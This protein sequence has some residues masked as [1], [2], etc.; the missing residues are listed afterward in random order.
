[1]IL[2]FT[3]IEGQWHHMAPT[4]FPDGQTPSVHD[5]ANR[6][7]ALIG[8]YLPALQSAWELLPGGA[9]VMGQGAHPET[10]SRKTVWFLLISSRFSTNSKCCEFYN[11]NCFV[12]FFSS[13]VLW[14]CC[15]FSSRFGADAIFFSLWLCLSNFSFGLRTCSQSLIS[16][17]G[18]VM[19]FFNLFISNNKVYHCSSFFCRWNIWHAS[20]SRNQRGYGCCCQKFFWCCHYQKHL[21]P[22][23]ILFH[24]S[25]WGWSYQ[26]TNPSSDITYSSSHICHLHTLFTF[27]IC[28]FPN[29][30]SHLLFPFS[31]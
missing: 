27:D 9:S 17:S 11:S 3:I 21:K 1:M 28:V 18:R 22:F 14:W 2:I 19:R 29:P 24:W 4:D 7:D 31:K 6:L 15:C 10:S 26:Y 16:N 12:A 20:I 5:F 23:H 13:D 8:T 30:S 25:E